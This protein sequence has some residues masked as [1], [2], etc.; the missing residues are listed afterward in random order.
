VNRCQA[1]LKAAGLKPTR[2]I[3][4]SYSLTIEATQDPS[5]FSFYSEELEGFTVVG[6]SVEDC[7]YKATWGMLEHI[8]L[9]KEPGLPVPPR[10][11]RS[12]GDH[13][14]RSPERGLIRLPRLLLRPPRAPA[15][16]WGFQIPA[17]LQ[18]A[19]RSLPE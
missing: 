13:P 7:L 9:L 4:L 2:M 1:I 11:S 16:A 17:R 12:A 14:E 15:A 8:E 6:T 5:F 3:D 10:E 19:R 18:D